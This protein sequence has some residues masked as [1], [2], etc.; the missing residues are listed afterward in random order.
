MEALNTRVKKSLMLS[1]LKNNYGQ[2]QASC[3][4]VGIDRSTHY[5]WLKTD[6]LYKQNA[7]NESLKA[8]LKSRASTGD[9]SK[10]DNGYAYLVHCIGTNFYKIGISKISYEARLS[11]MQSGC[12]YELRLLTTAHSTHYKEVEKILHRKFKQ[13]RIRG[14]WFELSQEQMEEVREYFESNAQQQ[15][16]FEF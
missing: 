4:D 7:L 2:V 6:E 11:T 14:E 8:S 13:F 1:A 9:Y 16:Q 10:P 15:T 12:P 5:A 3:V